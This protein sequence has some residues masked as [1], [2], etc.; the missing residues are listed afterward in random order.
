MAS[1]NTT[2]I[3][4]QA[5]GAKIP[6]LSEAIPGLDLLTK[7]ASSNIS[8]ELSGLPSADM[9][10]TSNAYFGI[11]SGMPSSDFVRNRG[12]DLY[13]NQAENRK[14]QGLKDLMGLIGG[15]SGTV[16]TTPA[17]QQQQ[18]QFDVSTGLQREQMG[19]QGDQFNRNLAFQQWLKSQELGLQAGA[20]GN[21]FLRTY[22]SFL[23]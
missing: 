10:R 11:N 17:L 9:A 15:M 20:L 18:G 16:A 2:K 12:F 1:L 4:G 7:N 19:Q 6:T 14:S 23:N 8:N 5:P 3:I 13:Q 21:D 22:G